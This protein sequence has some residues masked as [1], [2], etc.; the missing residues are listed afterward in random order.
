MPN[1]QLL[2]NINHKDLKI[3]TRKSAEFGD[4]VGGAILFPQEFTDAQKIYPIFFQKMP[5]TGEFQAVA[6][7]GFKD[8]ENLFLND[9]GWD[10]AYVPAVIEREPFLIGFQKSSNP[11][12]APSPMIHIDMDSPRISKTDEGEAVFQTYGGNSAYIDRI[13]K[14]LLLIHEGVNLS[15]AM[16]EALLSLDLIEPFVLDVAF[17]NGSEYK[18]TGYYTIN[19]EKLFALDDATLGQL[20]R[21]GFLH[22]A[23][24]V[25]VSTNNV[26]NLIDRKNKILTGKS[27]INS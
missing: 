10:A 17:N 13:S 16:F 23:Y 11:D 26:R 8:S 1:H 5:D 19:Q 22:Y 6:I 18:S 25:L 2:N 27:Q 9:A 3:I 20:H 12:D 21:T 4:A 15:K 14:T 24:M 7:F